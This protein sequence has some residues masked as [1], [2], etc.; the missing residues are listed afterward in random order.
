MSLLSHIRMMYDYSYWAY[1]LVWETSILALTDEQFTRPHDYSMGSVHH[2]TV[3]CISAEW[4]WFSRMRGIYPT[5]MLNPT[6]Y[7]ARSDVRAKWDEVETMVRGHL[8]TL[9]EDALH[10]PFAY[11]IL[12]GTE[13]TQPLGAILL[14]V[15]NHG[16]DHR[17]QLLAQMHAMGV[18]TVAQD[19][20]FYLRSRHPR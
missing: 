20:I 15:V 10:Q 11:K 1:K 9:T 2:Q 13:D 17:A 12:N 14:H 18:P 16:T 5:A 7:P 8:D 19:L 6:D 4:I 3:H